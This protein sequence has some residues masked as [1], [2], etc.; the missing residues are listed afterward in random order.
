MEGLTKPGLAIEYK[1]FCPVS[2]LRSVS[3]LTEGAVASQLMEHRTVRNL[4]LKFHSA[5]KKNHSTESALLKVK[6]DTLMNMEEQKVTLLVLLD[7]S[8][9]FDTVNHQVLLERLRSRF[10]VTGTAFD[11]FASYLSGRVHRI[12]MVVLQMHFILINV[13]LRASA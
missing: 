13:Y 5:Y 2:N 4:H 3:K 10:G 8:S 9:A 7:L 6:N 12:S 1:N 11:W